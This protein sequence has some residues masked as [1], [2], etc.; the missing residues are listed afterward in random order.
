VFTA[1]SARRLKQ[2]IADCELSTIPDAGHFVPM[3]KP[4]QCARVIVD[5][6]HRKLAVTG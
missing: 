2:I 4:E 1:E 6:I 3:G 5:F